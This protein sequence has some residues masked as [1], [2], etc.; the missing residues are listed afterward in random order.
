MKNLKKPIW[1]EYE[2]KTNFFI[3][4]NTLISH[5]VDVLDKQKTKINPIHLCE[6]IE[7]WHKEQ[8]KNKNKEA[9]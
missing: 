9:K 5:L 8:H 6:A 4:D 3:K 1:H 2:F 7:N